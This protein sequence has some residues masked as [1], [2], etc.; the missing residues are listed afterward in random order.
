MRT[1]NVAVKLLLPV[2]FSDKAKRRVLYI[3]NETSRVQLRQTRIGELHICHTTNTAYEIDLLA[4]RSGRLTYVQIAPDLNATMADVANRNECLSPL[5]TE[6]RKKIIGLFQNPK[7]LYCLYST[8]LYV[9]NLWHTLPK[10]TF[11]PHFPKTHFNNI[12]ASTP[13]S[14]EYLSLLSFYSSSR[15]CVSL[16]N[17]LFF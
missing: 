13:R 14:S 11:Q 3:H 8:T 4:S 16:G 2:D 5:K 7:I 6:H 12:L 15:T 1:K 10:Q 17:V 9:H